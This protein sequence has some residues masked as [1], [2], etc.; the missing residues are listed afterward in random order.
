MLKGTLDEF[1][2]PDI[3]RLLSRSRK[4]GR[5]DVLRSAGQGSV[6]FRDGDVYF[7]ESSV[8]R[9]LLGQK[10]VKAR[11]LTQG[12][13][14]RALDEQAESG[15]R[16]GDLLRARDSV[17]AEQL[18]AALR[19]QVED[20]AFDLLRWE[21]GEFDWTLDATVDAEV[22]LRV[23]VENLIM[24]AS[25]RLDEWEII[26]RKI[27]S[28]D[29]VVAMAPTPPDGA[30]QI[31]I[32]PG[33][34][35]VLVLVNGSR[36]VMEIA[37]GVG[38]DVFDTM[39]TL[40]GLMAAGLIEI[41]GMATTDD[42]F[43]SLE[44][45][46]AE[47]AATPGAPSEVH[48]PAE[49]PSFHDEAAAAPAA[50]E[51]VIEEPAAAEPMPEEPLAAEPMAVEPAVDEQPADEQSADEE[52]AAEPVA[53]APEPAP[54]P[55]SDPVAET[56]ADAF[57][58]PGIAAETGPADVVDDAAWDMESE[59]TAEPVAA[60]DGF[61]DSDPFAEEVLSAVANEAPATEPDVA[62]ADALDRQAAEFLG[63]A[64]EVETDIPVSARDSDPI[65]DKTAAV[66]ELSNLFKQSEV[67]NRPTFLVPPLEKKHEDEEEEEM[68][69]EEPRRVEDDE[70]IT[71]G[72]IS[73]L[74]DGVK[75]L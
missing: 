69:P 8:S 40:Y 18:E 65:A 58:D 11:A 68:E 23:S 30:A 38:G 24:E 4:T 27:P 10:L 39:R 61:E 33:E 42:D 49:P 1:A 67:D 31:N 13:L 2:L 45:L 63:T 50:D 25:R 19:E 56:E 60:A 22:E 52:P 14:M 57:V 74:I 48:E 12:E 7:A 17:T 46:V 43:V 53:L 41:P 34:W 6:F 55:V 54:E 47:P 16:L 5:L 26:K 64:D 15:G 29:C 66:R 75:G 37:E 3:F 62:V 71:R 44:S 9:E 51:I 21:M 59:T 20:A 73:R 70:E 36:T 72:L 28:E 32:T 35:R